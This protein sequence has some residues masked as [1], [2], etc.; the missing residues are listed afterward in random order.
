MKARGW[1]SVFKF[2]CLLASVVAGWQSNVHAEE[3]FFLLF[4]IWLGVTI[5]MDFSEGK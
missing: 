4:N 3:F 5:L 1:A 2:V